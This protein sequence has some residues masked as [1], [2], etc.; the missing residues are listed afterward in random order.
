MASPYDQNAIF[1]P[2]FASFVA[3]KIHGSF[4]PSPNY[5]PPSEPLRPTTSEHRSSSSKPRGITVL[6]SPS[7]A[8]SPTH[9]SRH[10]SSPHR[11]NSYVAAGAPATTAVAVAKGLP[12]PSPYGQ[13]Q[14][15]HSH[16]QY[17]P[18]EGYRYQQDKELPSFR[19]PTSRQPRANRRPTAPSAR[20]SMEMQLLDHLVR[21]AEN[22]VRNR[23]Y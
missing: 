6:L 18:P 9:R 12:G 11:T 8:H 13:Q 3:R 1:K 4:T 23:F 14:Y 21:K 17:N 7:G 15:R 20:C 19:H 2:T 5:H 10:S 16:A 22:S